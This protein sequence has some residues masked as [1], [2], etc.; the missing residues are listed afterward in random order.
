M[1]KPPRHTVGQTKFEINTSLIGIPIKLARSHVLQHCL[2]DHRTTAGIENNAQ[3]TKT[4]LPSVRQTERAVDAFAD[5]WRRAGG[6]A[7][8]AFLGSS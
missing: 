8:Q 5:T 7:S 2:I 6:K 4:E 1:R 3:A